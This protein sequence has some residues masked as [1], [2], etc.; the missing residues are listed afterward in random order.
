MLVTHDLV[1]TATSRIDELAKPSK[2]IPNN[3]IVYTDLGSVNDMHHEDEL[4]M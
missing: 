1:L 4:S 2:D 3:E